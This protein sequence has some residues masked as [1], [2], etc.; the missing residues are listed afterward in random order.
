MHVSATPP[1]DD[2]L[3][4]ILVQAMDDI[5]RS[6][7]SAWRHAHP[8]R[9]TG[10]IARLDGVAAAA[11]AYD[12]DVYLHAVCPLHSMLAEAISAWQSDLAWRGAAVWRG[13]YRPAGDGTDLSDNCH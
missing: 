7:Y 12:P 10:D 5:C 11:M 9:M 3:L 1:A 2:P 8:E 6:A 4:P 13:P